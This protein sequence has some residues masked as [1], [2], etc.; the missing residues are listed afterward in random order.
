MAGRG[1]RAGGKLWR[2]APG[3]RD[4]RAWIFGKARALA[5]ALGLTLA[6]SLGLV[7]LL[8]LA[9]H[10]ED[11]LLFSLNATSAAVHAAGRRAHERL[12]IG[13]AALYVMVEGK[14]GG[15]VT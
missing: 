9:V 7:L 8:F 14:H 5:R 1:G 13:A 12:Q 11:A 3:G 2:T 15:A 4:E 10:V 6:G